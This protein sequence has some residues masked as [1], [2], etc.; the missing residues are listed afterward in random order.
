MPALRIDAIREAEA[1][2]LRRAVAVG[3]AAYERSLLVACAYVAPSSDIAAPGSH[4]CFSIATNVGSGA[5]APALQAA[6]PNP[7]QRWIDHS[8]TRE[9]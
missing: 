5:F 3:S 9:A 1:R 6:L 4:E 2:G 8:P 7:I